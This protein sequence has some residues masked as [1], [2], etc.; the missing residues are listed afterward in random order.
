MNKKY[1]KTNPLHT[2]FLSD[3]SAAGLEQVKL[4]LKEGQTEDFH[5]YLLFIILFPGALIISI[6]VKTILKSQ[7]DIESFKY[8]FREKQILIILATA[9]Y[10][11]MW[12]YLLPIMVICWN[13]FHQIYSWQEFFDSLF[14]W[15]T[16]QFTIV[17]GLNFLFSFLALQSFKLTPA[18]EDRYQALKSYN[19]EQYQRPIEELILINETIRKAPEMMQ[20]LIDRTLTAMMANDELDPETIDKVIK[21]MQNSYYEIADIYSFDRQHSIVNAHLEPNDLPILEEKQDGNW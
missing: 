15:A 3:S 9:A 7:E 14:Q 6:S 5:H 4:L 12:R 8:L 2:L 17:F 19:R 11:A 1:K 13:L 20:N 18:F 21:M 16:F 10:I